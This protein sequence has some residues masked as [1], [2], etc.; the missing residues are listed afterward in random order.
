MIE[1]LDLEPADNWSREFLDALGAWKEPIE[2][3]FS[4]RR[5]GL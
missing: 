4:P 5:V 3:P 1:A 2:R